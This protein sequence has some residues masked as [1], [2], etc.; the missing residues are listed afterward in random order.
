MEI[1]D[2]QAPPSDALYLVSLDPISPY[3]QIVEPN[4]VTFGPR[5]LMSRRGQLERTV[6]L[7]TKHKV[8]VQGLIDA[9]REN[10][11]WGQV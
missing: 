2:L 8:I 1:L 5:S 10:L 3:P 7:L 6:Y 4:R 9:T 11:V